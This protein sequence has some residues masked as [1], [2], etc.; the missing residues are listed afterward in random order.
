MR[1]RIRPRTALKPGRT[2]VVGRG[3][4]GATL[5]DGRLGSCAVRFSRTLRRASRTA[6]RVRL[7]SHSWTVIS[8]ALNEAADRHTSRNVAF[9]AASAALG[10]RATRYATA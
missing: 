6:R 8:A 10:S 3:S 1:T 2:F 7:V 9:T 5:T 4:E